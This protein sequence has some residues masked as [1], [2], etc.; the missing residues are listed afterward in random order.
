MNDYNIKNFITLFV[1]WKKKDKWSLHEIFA[2][3]V[4]KRSLLWIFP[5]SFY[6]MTLIKL[7][8]SELSICLEIE[9]IL[10]PIRKSSVLFVF[11][12]DKFCVVVCLGHERNAL[13]VLICWGFSLVWVTTTT[14]TSTLNC[15]ICKRLM[16]PF[17]TFF[18][19]LHFC[20]FAA[21]RIRCL[22]D[23]THP[24]VCFCKQFISSFELTKLPQYFKQV[25]IRSKQFYAD[26]LLC[27]IN[28]FFK[29]YSLFAQ[30][31]NFI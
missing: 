14:S 19:V 11:L 9:Y 20:E 26:M 4:S 5:E 3:V 30:T 29:G 15:E 21:K 23:I 6:I 10:M 8:S 18:D 12:E 13:F 22:K 2:I 17:A 16:F 27:R 28:N 7:I 24:A 31:I 1:E 25:Q